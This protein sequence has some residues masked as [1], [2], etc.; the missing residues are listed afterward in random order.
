[1]RP[2]LGE[3]SALTCVVC[4]CVFVCQLFFEKK[5][6]AGGP[7]GSPAIIYYSFPNQIEKLLGPQKLSMAALFHA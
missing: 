4:V 5:I 1:M 3:F 6:I 7:E 2:L